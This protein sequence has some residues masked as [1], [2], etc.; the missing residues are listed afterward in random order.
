MLSIL[1]REEQDLERIWGSAW[2]DGKLLE[3][4]KLKERDTIDQQIEEEK[5]DDPEMM[6]VYAKLFKAH[7]AISELQKEKSTALANLAHAEE[8]IKE[9][10]KFIRKSESST[11]DR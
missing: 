4:H 1:T 2:R 7:R 3:H 6:A 9:L 11:Q 10:Q 8:K 5:S